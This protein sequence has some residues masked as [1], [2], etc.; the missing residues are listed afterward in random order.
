M[1]FPFR[2][3]RSFPVCCSPLRDSTRC[4][5]WPF[6]QVLSPRR[7][8]CRGRPLLSPG[9]QVWIL[10][11]RPPIAIPLMPCSVSDKMR[12]VPARMA[13]ESVQLQ[14]ADLV[15]QR[16]FIPRIL[17][18]KPF[19]GCTLTHSAGSAG[20]LSAEARW[21]TIFEAC[22]FTAVS[23]EERHRKITYH[24]GALSVT[25]ATARRFLQ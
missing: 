22:D 4:F 13:L 5:F 14:I 16:I 18:G 7:G 21:G 6:K 3:R 9:C 24:K 23:A 11:C 1:K 2:G 15:K 17:L 25:A 8:H 10:S 20:V 19:A 12:A